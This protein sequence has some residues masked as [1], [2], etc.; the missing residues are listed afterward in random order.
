MRRMLM[1]GALMW[2]VSACGEKD[3]LITIHTEF[4]DMKVILYDET[5]QH[6][7]NFI[8]LANEGF[9]DSLLWHRVMKEFMIQGG[10]NLSRYAKPGARVGNGGAP[11]RLP[12]EIVPGKLHTRGSVAAARGPDNLNPDKE[13]NGS[14]FYIVQGKKFT[15]EELDEIETNIDYSV[16]QPKLWELLIR[17]SNMEL[18]AKLEAAST[19][20]NM[21]EIKRLVLEA[22]PIVEAEYGKQPVKKF[23]PEERELYKKI[24]GSPHLDGAYTVFGEVLEGMYVVDSIAKYQTDRNARP[25]KDVRMWIDVEEVPRSKITKQYGYEYPELPDQK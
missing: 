11:Y 24:G 7:Q 6:K 3:Q 2:I 15:D 22:R 8:K 17:E 4:G 23:T 12:A 14:Q 16:L 20:R 21:V 25:L 13:S 10:D 1:I 19:N 18:R 9:Y 5:P